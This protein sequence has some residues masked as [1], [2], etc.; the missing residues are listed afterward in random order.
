MNK[1][2]VTVIK[3]VNYSEADKVL[4]VFG[5]EYGKFT[6]FAKGIRKL[7]SKNRGNMQTLCTSNIS[8]YEGRGLPVLTESA[9]VSSL[10][11]DKLN[12]E[13]IGRILFLLNK[14]LQ[15]YDPYP[16][17]FDAL[18][19]ALS[20][21]LGLETTNK[22]RIK[23]LKEMGFLEDFSECKY[24]HRKEN[25]NYFDKYNFFLVCNNCHSTKGGELLGSK[26]YE[27]SILT[28]ALD[29]YVKRVVEEI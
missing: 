21:D 11:F 25:L 20:R 9:S 12:V 16:K 10:N 8:F 7:N 15:E 2:I 6:V 1:D 13:N 23:F 17:L 18:Q 22:L 26:P 4:T 14:F 29:R 27:S 5:R 19:V 28:N 24:C 3:S